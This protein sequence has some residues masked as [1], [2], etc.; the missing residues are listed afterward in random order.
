MSWTEETPT[1]LVIHWDEKRPE[2]EENKDAATFSAVSQRDF[3]D[4][5]LHLCQSL[6]DREC[7][8]VKPGWS[9][10]ECVQT[11]NTLPSKPSY[12]PHGSPPHGL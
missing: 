11:P 9:T 10:T 5:S 12:L 7:F 4:F 2:E 6:G 1:L 8:W 3:W